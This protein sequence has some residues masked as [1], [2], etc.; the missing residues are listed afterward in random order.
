MFGKSKKPLVI[1]ITFT[2]WLG[3][4]GFTG[5]QFYSQA[6]LQTE[7]YLQSRHSN[8]DFI[9]Q[10]NVSSLLQVHPDGLQDKL[11][12]AR[13]RGLIDFYILQKGLEPVFFENNSGN[14]ADLNHD[15]VNFNRLVETEKLKFKTVKILEY[16]LTAGF[17]ADKGEILWQTLKNLLPLMVKDVGIVTLL[18]GL[19][20]FFQLKDI[21]NISRIISSRSRSALAQVQTT[22]ME[23][24]TLL[25]GALGLEAEKS[26]LQGVSE[27]Y[28]ATVGPALRHELTSHRN[29]P[30]NFVATVCRVDLN[31]YTQMFF[32]NDASYLNQILN[33]Y[34]ARARE[35]ID[36]YDGLIYQFV[37]DEIVFEFK[38][39][40]AFP[41]NSQALAIACIRDLFHEAELIEKSLPANANHYFK[42]KGSL[43]H[44]TMNF[45]AL[46]QGHA[47]S[48]LPLIESVRLLSL[49]DEKD[50]QLLSF[51]GESLKATHGL[52][53]I[54][55][56]QRNQLKG[57]KEESQI[58]FVRDF[59]T[60]AQIL[61]N[62]SWELL[63]YFRSDECLLT[64]IH[65]LGD[66]T[67]QHETSDLTELF[68]GIKHHK[69]FHPSIS[70]IK[71]CGETL[72][73]FISGET[74][75]RISPKSLA[76][77]V[78]FVG[79]IVPQNQVQGNLRKQLERL[80]DHSN[81]RVQSNAMVAM[82][83]HQVPLN[84]LL[85]KM[86]SEN[87]R[88]SADAIIEAAKVEVNA[89][90]FRALCRLIENEKDV[91]NRSGQYAVHQILGYYDKVDPVFM[92][93]N[94]YLI[95][96]KTW[97]QDSKAS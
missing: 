5:Y 2:F 82:G 39:E 21:I 46:D 42:L 84:M 63:T 40:M 45:V 72:E 90:V 13:K 50:H 81:Y 51:F 58:C 17:Y 55:R 87:N 16:R 89:E 60:L 59:N 23:A 10:S 86:I 3:Y 73:S 67:H 94:A 28:G 56:S 38:D 95:K 57:F 11:S 64:L 41:A 96:M 24:E 49:I 61:E 77:F 66:M 85:S 33:S 68:A 35:V 70:V 69:T 80:L 6:A 1:L 88:V 79:R 93:T 7:H 30:Y 4:T 78:G 65:K 83:A 34:F 8:L 31:G 62:R 36:R 9:L 44:G 91:F 53:Q 97:H 32:K 29:P 48:G 20:A 47:L 75:G 22:S 27:V 54:S 52:A 15:Y 12:Q 25:K 74:E 18:L 43:A 19:I 14:L 71:S 37:G 92:Q 76:S 26:R